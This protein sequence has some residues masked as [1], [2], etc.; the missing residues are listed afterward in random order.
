MLI[1]IYVGFGFKTLSSGAYTPYRWA[2]NLELNLSRPTITYHL[3]N[4][5]RDFI[6]HNRYLL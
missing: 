4:H 3:N 1:D 2:S 5:I 6:C